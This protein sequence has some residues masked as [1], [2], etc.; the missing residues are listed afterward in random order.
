MSGDKNDNG[1]NVEAVQKALN[2]PSS[3]TD[4][5]L[6]SLVAIAACPLFFYGVY[7][8]T[9]WMVLLGL[10]LGPLAMLVSHSSH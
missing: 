2:H 1:L 7:S 10:L 6:A 9:S 3:A 8:E 5:R 4:F